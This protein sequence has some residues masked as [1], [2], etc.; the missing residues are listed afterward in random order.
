MN[1]LHNQHPVKDRYLTKDLHL[2]A[3]L[4]SKGIPFVGVNRQ[5]KLCWFVFEKPGQCE[6]LE[7]GYY[8]KSVE[9]VAK[10]YADALRTLK[11]LVFY[12]D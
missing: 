4:Y 1:H 2:G 10:E 7:R 3:M 6:E 12:R 11:D 8:S 9:V 5:G